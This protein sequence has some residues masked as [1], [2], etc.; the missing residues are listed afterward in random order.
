MLEFQ[1]LQQ[2]KEKC[3]KANAELIDQAI[4]KLKKLITY[5]GGA[6]PLLSERLKS[7]LASWKRKSRSNG[8]FTLFLLV[9][10]LLMSL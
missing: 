8:S 2:P 1:F 4:G 5:I 10:C 9:L 3:E 6:S 7:V